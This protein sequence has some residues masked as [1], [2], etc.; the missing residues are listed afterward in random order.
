MSSAAE[1]TLLAVI[2]D[3]DTVTG[4][5]LAGIGHVDAQSR[6][7]FL[8][9]DNKTTS[10]TIESTFTEFTQNRPDIAIVMITQQVADEIRHLVD[11]HVEAYPAVLE[12]PSKNKPYD[13]TKDSVL[14]RVKKM[15]AE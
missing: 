14:N 6:S 11:G 4:M 1:R 2:G 15:V 9:V 3:E 5:L 13:P 10:S 8:V 7:N 12:I